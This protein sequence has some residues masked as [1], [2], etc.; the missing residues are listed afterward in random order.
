M[1]E[2]RGSKV[3]ATSRIEDCGSTSSAKVSGSLE[4]VKM[5][6]SIFADF[7]MFIA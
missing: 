7:A 5:D 1:A 6:V 4:V 3:E 2:R